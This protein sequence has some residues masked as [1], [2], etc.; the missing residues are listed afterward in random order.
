[1]CLIEQGELEAV[2]E[3]DDILQ[4]LEPS[5]GPVGRA[6]AP[7]EGGITNRNYRALMGGCEYVVRLHG[8]DT[9]LLGISRE[10]ERLANDT[11]AGLGIAPAVA[12]GFEGGLVTEFLACDALQAAEIQAR[13]EELGVALRAFHDSGAELPA[14]FWVPDLLGDY[15]R[16]IRARGAEPPEAYEQAIAIAGRI[17]AALGEATELRPCHNDLLAGNII[18]AR[19]S[20]RVMLV[21][22]EYAG[23]G[24]PWFDLGNL[25]V[26]NDFAPSTDNRLLAAYLGTA[27][28][29]SQEATLKLMR[30]L[31]DVREGAWG[32]MQA[33][34]SEL[35]FD[36]EG[37]AQEHFARMQAAA[38][39]ARFDRWLTAVAG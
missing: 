31:S 14:K 27:P 24:H 10:A 17:S 34:V 32:V 11:A 25:S 15:T 39:E 26:N 33:Q 22:W 21:D 38:G 30:I 19:D 4:R 9:D 8:K 6:P 23:M 2:G 13:A 29:E 28:S 12:A 20:G 1:V 5:L 18:L 7:L 35:E 36:F 37:Y 3:L 16:I